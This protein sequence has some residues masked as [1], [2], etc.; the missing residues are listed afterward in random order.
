MGRSTSNGISPGWGKVQLCLGLQDNFEDLIINF[1]NVYYLP[2]SSYNLVSLGLLNDSGIYYSNKRKTLYHVYLKRVQ[3]QVQWWKNSYLLK[4]LKLSDGAVHLLKINNNNYQWPC[5]L[6]KSIVEPTITF[7]STWHEQ[8]GHSNF[9]LLK[10]D[11]NWLDIPSINDSSRYICDSCFWA[12]ATKTYCQ[13]PHKQL[14]WPYQF[15]YTDLIKPINLVSFSRKRYFFTF[16]DDAIRMTDIYTKTKKSNWLKCLKAYHSLCRTRSK[17]NHPIELL[18]SD[19][20]SERQSDKA[21][22]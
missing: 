22:E 9:S 12:K 10:T 17:N 13:D 20:R 4:P 8:L 19:Y 6:L 11:I 15:I 18:K 1:R 14:E 2:N 21:N 3:V 7:L 16:T 5:Y